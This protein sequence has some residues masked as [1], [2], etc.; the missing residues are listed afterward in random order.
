MEKDRPHKHDLTSR[1]GG[2][3]RFASDMT[4]WA[5]CSAVENGEFSYRVYCFAKD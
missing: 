1:H 5:F 3:A 4:D 2:M